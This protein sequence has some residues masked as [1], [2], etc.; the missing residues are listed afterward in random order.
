MIPLALS[1]SWL[2]IYKYIISK[3]FEINVVAS[4]IVRAD[5]IPFN[6][7]P[8]IKQLY[9]IIKEKLHEPKKSLKIEDFDIKEIIKENLEVIKEYLD[10]NEEVKLSIQKV[11][12]ENNKITKDTYILQ[13]RLK[14]IDLLMECKQLFCT[15]ESRKLK[16][17]EFIMLENDLILS[18]YG[19]RFISVLAQEHEKYRILKENFKY[20]IKEYKIEGYST[21]CSEIDSQNSHF[22]VDNNDYIERWNKLLSLKVAD[23]LFEDIYQ[24]ANEIKID[25]SIELDQLKEINDTLQIKKSS[26][27][28]TIL[29]EKYK[30]DFKTVQ[31]TI[32]NALA[33]DVI[34]YNEIIKLIELYKINLSRQ[35]IIDNYL[36]ENSININF[37]DYS[38]FVEELK[39]VPENT[40]LIS[41]EKINKIKRLHQLG[42][43][44]KN[45]LNKIDEKEVSKAKPFLKEISNHKFYFEKLKYLTDKLIIQHALNSKET[46]GTL[47]ANLFYCTILQ[48]ELE[49]PNKE[50]GEID[51]KKAAKSLSNKIKFTQEKIAEMKQLTD[52]NKCEDYIAE[53]KKKGLYTTDVE[54]YFCEFKMWREWYISKIKLITEELQE[55]YIKESDSKIDFINDFKQLMNFSSLEL[56]KFLEDI[57]DISDLPFENASKLAKNLR[58]SIWTQQYDKVREETKDELLDLEEL[59]ALNELATDYNIKTD[60]W[61]ELV[62]LTENYDI[63]QIVKKYEKYGKEDILSKLL[64][65]KSSYYVCLLKQSRLTCNQSQ[66]KLIDKYIKFGEIL[67]NIR[68]AVEDIQ[69]IALEPP[70][71]DK[72]SKNNDDSDPELILYN[73]LV[74][75]LTAAESAK[76]PEEAYW[77]KFLR[78]KLIQFEKWKKSVDKYIKLKSKNKGKMDEVFITK[79]D[80]YDDEK[81]KSNILSQINNL[82]IKINGIDMEIKADLDSLSNWI[83]CAS[84]LIDEYEE[85]LPIN[86]LNEDEETQIM[87]VYNKFREL[88]LISKAKKSLFNDIYALGWLIRV[89]YLFKESLS[90]QKLKYDKWVEF[91]KQIKNIA[92]IKIISS[93]SLYRKFK[94]TYDMG[95]KMQDLYTKK[96]SKTSRIKLEEMEHFIEEASKWG[97]DLSEEICSLKQNAST[98]KSLQEKLEKILIETPDINQ[99]WEI[100][101]DL[102]DWPFNIDKEEKSI[103]KI[104][105]E[106][107]DIKKTIKNYLVILM[108]KGTDKT[109]KLSKIDYIV[110]KYKEL[111][112]I[113]AEGEKIIEDREKNATLFTSIK[114]SFESLSKKGDIL[115]DDLM[116]IENDLKWLKVHFETDE[117]LLVR[118]IT[119]L[120]IPSFVNQLKIFL[121]DSKP[122][123]YKFN[124]EDAEKLYKKEN[125]SDEQMTDDA[126]VIDKKILKELEKYINKK[127]KVINEFGDY[128]KWK[129]SFEESKLKDIVNFE[130]IYNL[131]LKELKNNRMKDQ[132]K[133]RQEAKK[134]KDEDRK[135]Q[136]DPD[137]YKNLKKKEKIKRKNRSKTDWYLDKGVDDDWDER[138]LKYAEPDIELPKEVVQEDNDDTDEAEENVKEKKRD[139]K[140]K[141]K[142]TSANKEKSTITKSTK[143]KWIKKL[144]DAKNGQNSKKVKVENKASARKIK[145]DSRS[146]ESSEKAKEDV[147]KTILNKIKD[148]RS[149]SELMLKSLKKNAKKNNDDLKSIASSITKETKATESQENKDSVNS[150]SKTK[151]ALKGVKKNNWKIVPEE[152]E[153][154]EKDD[155]K[156]IK[157]KNSVVQ[158]KGLASSIAKKSQDSAISNPSKQKNSLNKASIT[159][160]IASKPTILSGLK[161]KTAVGGGGALA[162]SLKKIKK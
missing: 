89:Q 62:K 116:Q 43:D 147:K 35:K 92:K 6:L 57:R 111:K 26:I 17:D 114:D 59:I 112:W 80:Y 34:P 138:Y 33:D 83:K 42:I 152:S 153:E 74:D 141:A 124:L 84:E 145:H 65:Y 93:S 162:A 159:S 144:A 122:T 135:Q 23:S 3:K 60:D 88:P 137:D 12:E 128:D 102:R 38:K 108:N 115:W 130:T 120:K 101:R 29:D 19:G 134:K 50:F 127:V 100:L 104:K 148:S 9:K 4:H 105:K 85:K 66:I 15:E 46:T 2:K 32:D 51:K 71:T 149:K 158:K 97:I 132:A 40:I 142:N 106:Y 126:I 68:N 14:W 107:E 77:F 82:I 41:E 13:N 123:K 11:L 78:D 81:I 91:D 5:I 67:E 47:N 157:N 28:E 146:E 21:N 161:R 119:K 143:E 154:S 117:D 160:S 31:K 118:S 22:I 36:D 125:D 131:K 25:I 99:Y 44:I 109:L 121:K 150:Q 90:G 1:N 63:S 113:F 45:N 48:K 156:I 151:K 72:F 73:K 139:K 20:I 95:T 39:E 49:N 10:H 30:V 94:E 16:I 58:I 96:K 98:F 27:K 133:K 75:Q 79:S 7:S 69:K 86:E 24:K 8:F 52:L 54:K 129:E 140:D 76:M 56:N 110:E 37:D 70:K 103:N 136:M 155:E 64:T 18:G 55:R 87:E 61:P 53:I